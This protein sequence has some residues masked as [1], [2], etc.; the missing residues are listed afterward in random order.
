MHD[1]DI[2]YYH[3]DHCDPRPPRTRAG[4]A[5]HETWLDATREE[6]EADIQAHQEADE[7]RAMAMN[8]RLSIIRGKMVEIEEQ[9]KRITS[10]V[11]HAKDCQDEFRADCKQVD[12]WQDETVD[13]AEDAY[14][15]DWQTKIDNIK[16]ALSLVQQARLAV[17]TAQEGD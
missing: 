2:D 12:E 10:Q 8:V 11:Q 14:F 15:M 17:E 9:L 7:T 6:V 13:F 3:E 1:D 5:E 4:S 16:E